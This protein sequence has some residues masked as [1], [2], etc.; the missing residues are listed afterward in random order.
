MQVNKHMKIILVRRISQIFFFILFVWFCIASTIGEKFF[1]IRGW[2]V[3]LFLE[4]DP[5]ISIGTILTTHKLYWPLLWSLLTVILT[6]IFGRFFCG[7][8]CPFGAIHQFTG[9]LWNRGSAVSKM[10]KLNIYRP[11][12]SV[13]YYILAV[14]L[15]AAIFPFS[16]SSLQIGL[17]DPISLITRTFNLMLL[18]IF[19]MKFNVTS[20]SGRFYEGAWLIF[21]VFG[22]AVM[23]NLFIPR[24]YCRFICPLG[25]LFG[26]LSRFAIFRIGK[27]HYNCSDCKRCEEFCEGACQPNGPIRT[28]ECV[29]CLNCREGCKEDVMTYST[30]PSRAGEIPEPDLSRKGFILSIAGGILILPVFRLGRQLDS[31]WLHSIIRPPGSLEE[32]EFLKRCIKC[33][34]CIRICPTNVLQPGSVEGGFENLWTPVLN[35]R[36]GSSGCQYNCT[37]CGQICPTSAIRPITLDEKH[38]KGRFADAGFIK[39]GTAFVDRNRCLPWSMDKPCIVCQENCPE[40]PKAIHTDEIFNTVRDGN[41]TVKSV[42]KNIIEV[43]GHEISGGKNLSGDYFCLIDGKKRIKIL[44][45]T[46]NSVV[47]SPAEKFNLFSGDKISIQVRLQRPYVDIERCTGCGICEHECPVSGKRAIRVSGVGES[48]SRNRAMLLKQ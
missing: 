28:S 22:A 23:L 34:E 47:I 8:L 46:E 40:S 42:Q 20:M 37:A 31:N 11:L 24:F 19:D 43:S 29:M 32:E 45:M 13:K 7:W 18:P 26:I 1:Q 14:F 10:V 4:L 25:A 30:I 44:S 2:P 35:N 3:N 48:R 27:N 33:G 21:L 38:G 12:Q 39:I 5:L 9:Y 36:I 6:I 15:I 16:T 41:L 17:L